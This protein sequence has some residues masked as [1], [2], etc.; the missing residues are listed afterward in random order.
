MGSEAKKLFADAQAMLRRIVAEKWLGA[1]AVV[2]FWP[3]NAVGDDIE[4]YGDGGQSRSFTF[5]RDVVEATIEAM[6]AGRGTYNVGGGEEATVNETIAILEELSGRSLGLRQASVVAGDQRR[7][8]ADT[9]AIRRDLGWA[10]TTP[11]RDGLAEQWEW[12]AARVAA[13]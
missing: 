5:V 13:S 4:L 12:A 2:G 6:R 10:P 11:L 1:T 9:S 7:S 3:A 8:F